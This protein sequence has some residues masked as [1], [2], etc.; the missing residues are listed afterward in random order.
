MT[1]FVWCLAGSTAVMVVMGWLL[2]TSG[3]IP[4][5]AVSALIF[6]VVFGRVR[7]QPS[8]RDRMRSFA[9]LCVIAGLAIIVL[10]FPVVRAENQTRAEV[11]LRLLQNNPH[12]VYHMPMP[13]TASPLPGIIVGA[14][15]HGLGVLILAIRRPRQTGA[16]KPPKV[17]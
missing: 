2:G 8:K 16:D 17:G 14:V 4:G 6:V 5:A 3:F 7:L 11:Y 15:V 13:Q 12:P 9:G 10:T 1:M